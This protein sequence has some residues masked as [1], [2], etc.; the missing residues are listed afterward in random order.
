MLHVKYVELPLNVA[1]NC[2]PRKCL[3]EEL[4]QELQPQ[5]GVWYLKLNHIII[6]KA[7]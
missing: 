1:N 4:N 7:Q 6:S 3:S 5:L 2:S